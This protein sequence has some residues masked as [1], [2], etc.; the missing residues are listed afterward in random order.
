MQAKTTAPKDAARKATPRRTSSVPP[1]KEKPSR[2]KKQARSTKTTEAQKKAN[3]AN[4]ARSTGPRTEAG[5]Q[6]SARNSLRHGLY[7][8]APQAILRGPYSEDPQEVA[9]FVAGIEDALAPRN[10]LEASTARDIA[11]LRLKIWRIDSLE[12]G[13]INGQADRAE[14]VVTKSQGSL[15]S[16]EME[17][18]WLARMLEWLDAERARLAGEPPP[19]GDVPSDQAEDGFRFDVLA[20]LM[21]I[22]CNYADVEDLWTKTKTPKTEVEWYRAFRLLLDHR[23]PGLEGLES[24]IFQ[25][26]YHVQDL[27]RERHTTTSIRSANS[28][29]EEMERTSELRGRLLKQLERAETLYRKWQDRPLVADDEENVGT[30]PI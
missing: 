29:L 9:A 21:R 30:N 15:K 19:D 11:M 4:A 17:Y 14:Q 2:A 13:L 16:L 24:W 10:A 6:E 5:K 18:E 22:A 28:L 26:G 1:I 25:H 8:K 27:I 20:Q 7:A 12:A 23:F 3:A